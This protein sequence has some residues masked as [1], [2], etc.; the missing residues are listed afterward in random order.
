MSI[1]Y[2]SMMCNYSYRTNDNKIIDVKQV[3]VEDFKKFF[4]KILNDEYVQAIVVCLL[5]DKTEDIY[6]WQRPVYSNKIK[7]F[8]GGW[9]YVGGGWKHVG[10]FKPRKNFPQS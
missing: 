7:K 8:V 2:A 9:Q 1:D 10:E 5:K 4:K 3:A 6:I